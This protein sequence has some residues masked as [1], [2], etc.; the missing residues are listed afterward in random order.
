[1]SDGVR[2]CVAAWPQPRMMV[3]SA[4]GM[5]PGCRSPVSARVAA[6]T[7]KCVP[8]HLTTKFRDEPAHP[9]CE[10]KV[11]DF[12]SRQQLR[13]GEIEAI[14]KGKKEKHDEQVQFAAYKQ[15]YDDAS[16][17]KKRGTFMTDSKVENFG[18]SLME[19]GVALVVG[20]V[21]LF[22]LTEP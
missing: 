6:F 11:S 15:F 1:M 12:E 4:G 19:K 22:F 21:V 10:Q 7:I 16:V 18:G 3:L 9:T 20:R 8:V 14:A 17:E 13:A 5:V 2:R